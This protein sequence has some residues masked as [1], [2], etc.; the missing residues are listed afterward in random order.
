MEKIKQSIEYTVNSLEELS[1]QDRS[2]VD[3]ARSAMNQAYAPYSNFLVGCALLL[4]NNEIIPGSNQENASFPAGLCAEK[5]GLSAASSRFPTNAVV[6][7]A[8]I[9]SNDKI[10]TAPCGIC[11]QSLIEYEMRFDQNIAILLCK[12][13]Q[14][15]YFDSVK[16]LLPFAFNGSAIK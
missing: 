15:Y 13:E 3:I 8:I 7:I 4:D 10:L 6:K 9:T 11:R 1:A 16:L 2:L 14:I 5:V 12:G